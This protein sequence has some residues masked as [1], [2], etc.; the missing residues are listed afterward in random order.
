MNKR[1]VL[2]KVLWF[3]LLGLTIKA[4]LVLSV[5]AASQGTSNLAAHLNPFNWINKKGEETI[6]ML[7]TGDIMLGRYIAVLR[8]ERGGDFP[9]TY[10]PEV[11]STV[12]SNLGVQE[13][14]LV[15]GNLEG[16]IT[17]S[18]YINPGT[19]MIFNF[20]PEV[21]D[22]LKKVGF[23]T[24]DMANNHV[25]NMGRQG[26]DQTYTYLSAVDLEGFGHP[27]TPN[28]DY[29]TTIYEFDTKTIGFLGLNDTD[30]NL[31]EELTLAKIT[32][33]D[34]EVDFLVVGIHWGI[35]YEKTARSSITELAHS[36]VDSGADMVWGHHPH[37][38]QN[39]EL[40]N[41]APIYYS[42]GNFVFDQ[43]W[44]AAT[45]EGLVVGLRL[46]GDKI[47]TTEIYV[48]LINQ[49]EPRPRN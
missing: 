9:F 15:I 37:V 41:G 32:Q 11:I 22:L 49:G 29:S 7:F 38:I 33:L 44:S 25:F 12:A 8:E 19:S 45:Q 3:G 16:P 35:E 2:H 30:F 27:D 26:L 23:T 4:S 5:L 1:H 43:Y 31:D 6:T 20:Q 48:D 17:D 10:M 39:W 46:D 47:T 40:Y 21:A 28:G 42:L 13:L 14:D 34:Q 24:L 36:F 18:T